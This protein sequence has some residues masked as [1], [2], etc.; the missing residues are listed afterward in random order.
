[1]DDYFLLGLAGFG[2]VGKDTVADLIVDAYPDWRKMSF[3]EP[4]RSIAAAANPIVGFGED[5]P[6]RYN[7]AIAHYGY[8][9]AKKEVPEVREF[10][11]RLGTD[12]IR[13]IVGPDFWVEIGARDSGEAA[14]PVV[15]ADVRFKNEARFLSDVGFVVKVNRPG[16][17]PVNSHASE[18]DL[19]DWE[20]DYVLENDGTISDLLP[21]ITL[22]LSDLN[23]RWDNG[24]R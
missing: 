7:D 8:D 22:M 20:F 9:L 15:F 1:M 14:V 16:Y 12:G 13:G 10:L 2:G 5:G 18:N 23:D 21:K 17:D 24:H 4:L 11:Q 6:I 19:H 3:A